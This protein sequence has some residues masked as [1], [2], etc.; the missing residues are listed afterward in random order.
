MAELVGGRPQTDMTD[1]RPKGEDW[2]ENMRWEEEK[3]WTPAEED[4]KWSV[5]GEKV[6]EL[7]AGG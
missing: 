1:E 4:P 3:W 2:H 7:G 5:K 6:L